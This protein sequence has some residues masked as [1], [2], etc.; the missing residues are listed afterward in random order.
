MGLTFGQSGAPA[1]D[2]INLDALLSMSLMNYNKTLINQISSSNAFWN[3]TKGRWKG[4]DGGI[5]CKQNLLYAV[6]EG[7][8]YGGYDE[9]QMS[10]TDGI[11]QATWEW[12]QYANSVIIS[13]EEEYKNNNGLDDLLEA[14]IQQVELGSQEFFSKYILQGN[15]A[16][17]SSA[18]IATPYTN[19]GNGTTFVDPLAKLVAFDPTTSTEIGG[20]NQSTYS[21]WRNRTLTMT[22]T[23]EKLFMQQMDNMYNTCSVGEA[24][25]EPDT[26]LVDQTTYEMWRSAYYTYYRRTAD[27]DNNYPFANFKFN[28]ARVMWDERVPDVY[29][30][31]LATTTYGTAYFLNMKFFQPYYVNGRNF[32]NQPF[33]KPYN[34]DAK[35]SIILWAGTLGVAQRRK[36]G[37][38]GKI[39]R[40]LA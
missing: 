2:T 4:K 5:A 36:Q 35:S 21:W 27:S 7:T 11:T 19:T 25:G 9:I 38:V 33:Q 23:T 8:T 13:G 24:G 10:P 3:E 32:A 34:Q 17:L 1:Q 6:S 20:I 26:I 39:P 22:A 18:S 37:V 15:K 16:N 30:D 40:T 31:A 28:K 29:T 14:K 12:R